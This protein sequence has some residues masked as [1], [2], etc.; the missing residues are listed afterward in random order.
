MTNATPTKTRRVRRDATSAKGPAKAPKT[1][2]ESKPLSQTGDLR[3]IVFDQYKPEGLVETT[4]VEQIAKTYSIIQKLTYSF[5]L[6]A[7]LD[8]YFAGARKL[9]KAELTTALRESANR[10][11]IISEGFK[12]IGHAIREL[13]AYRKSPL[14][15]RLDAVDILTFRL[16]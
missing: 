9:S 6:D 10:D 5:P 3:A 14:S 13:D 12:L 8:E 7:V 15:P 16:G 1:T 11:R 4:I 2:T